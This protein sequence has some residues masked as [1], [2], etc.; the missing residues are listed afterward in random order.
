MVPVSNA[1]AT[2][3]YIATLG[4]GAE[5]RGFASLWA[6]EHVVLFDR[7]TSRYP[8]ADDGRLVTRGDVGPLDPFAAL[9][10]LAARTKR[11]RLGTG[12]CL[13]PQRNPLYTAK[14]V[15]S[16]DWLSNGRVDFGIGIGWLAEEFAALGVPFARRGAR[17]RAYIEV[18]KR[19]WCDPVSEYHGEFY[20]LPACRQYP[21]PVQQPHPPIHVGGE[22]DAALKRAAD[23]GQGWFGFNLDPVHASER[24]ARLDA[25]LAERG[26]KRT[27]VA[28]SVS[29]PWRM[30]VTREIVDRFRE[31]GVDQLILVVVVRDRDELLRRLDA[32][33]T[34][35]SGAG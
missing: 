28:V 17:A 35:V 9:A 32:H 13:V 5:A 15:A 26:R 7:Y 11:I 16:V 3:E 27:D 6:P 12:I 2:P 25:I 8:Y 20:D 23:F 22:S 10:F 4:E 1:F 33:A 19:L 14:E 30:A 21:K 34:L 18:M 29:P 31:L 24:L